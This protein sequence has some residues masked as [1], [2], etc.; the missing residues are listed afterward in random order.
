ME[1]IEKKDH[2]NEGRRKIIDRKQPELGWCYRATIS[3]AL[4][5]EVLKFYL[6]IREKAEEWVAKWRG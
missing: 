4:I 6:E 5:T 1:N 2:Q 3:L